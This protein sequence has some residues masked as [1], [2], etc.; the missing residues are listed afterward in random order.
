MAH[1]DDS[2]TAVGY[3][4]KKGDKLI[5][6]SLGIKKVKKVKRKVTKK[7]ARVSKKSMQSI[8]KEHVSIM[9]GDME[10]LYSMFGVG[11]EYDIKGIVDGSVGVDF[12]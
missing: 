9:Q 7:P 1:W 12:D 5:E 2:G 10:Q 8:V 11:D 6:K 3:E 4:G